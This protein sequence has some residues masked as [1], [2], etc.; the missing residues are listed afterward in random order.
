[1][2]KKSFINKIL[3]QT[4]KPEGFFGRMILRGMNMGHSKLSLWGMSQLNWQANW[5]VLDI[6]CGG[7]ANLEKMLEYC[8]K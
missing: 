8:P 3:Q 1:M 6:G 4:R 2:R 7:G 5:N